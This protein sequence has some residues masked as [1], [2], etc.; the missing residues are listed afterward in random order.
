MNQAHTTRNSSFQVKVNVLLFRPR[1]GCRSLR[2]R[3]HL[4]KRHMKVARLSALRIGRLYPRMDPLLFISIGGKILTKA[5]VQPGGLSQR[6]ISKTALLLLPVLSDTPKNITVS[7]ACPIIYTPRILLF[8]LLFLSYIPPQYYCFCCLS[9]QIY[10]HNIT[11]SA[12]C[13]V[14]VTS[15]AH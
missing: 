8:L 4:D 1:K 9:Y 15:T 13:G 6:K 7:F 5:V 10:P 12:A 3:G 2:L 14:K 11:V